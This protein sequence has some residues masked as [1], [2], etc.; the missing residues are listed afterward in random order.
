MKLTILGCT[1]SLGGPDGPASGYLLTVDRMPA[2]LMDI[3]P[4]VLAKMQTVHQP[5]DAHVVFSH[6]HP[7]HCLDFPSLMVWRRFSPSA[8][9]DRRHM[10]LG[11]RDTP[12]RLGR[13]SADTPDGIDDMSDTFAFNA[14][15]DG[16]SEMVDR[17]TITPYATVHPIESYALRVE[18]SGVSGGVIAYSGDSGWTDNLID[19]ARGADIFLCEAT[20]GA[21]SEG[22]TPDMHLSGAEAGR[23]ARE[24]GVD[25]LVLVHIPPWGDPLGALKAARSEF[26]GE[27]IVGASGME[28][29]V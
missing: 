5:E 3:G 25:K 29:E 13:L 21:T 15:T 7:D 18:E 4:G 22:K 11:P 2:L 17:L 23:I 8:T 27:V 20:W 24:A 12:V 10:C 9:T 28:F 14:W 6:L 1:G 16:V 19:C 26:S